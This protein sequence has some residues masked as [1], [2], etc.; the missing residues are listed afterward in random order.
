MIQKTAKKTRFVDNGDGT[1]TD[2]DNNVMWV[3]NDTWLE[4]GRQVTWHESQD[5]ARKMNEK[6][7]AG[8]GNWRIPT[9]SE[10]R[11][12]FDAEASN[13]DVEG[14]EIH[15]SPVFSPKCG[16]S[17]WTSETRGAKA[18]MGYDLRSDY[19][20][21]LAKENDGFPSAV[22]LVRQLQ[23]AATLKDGEPRFINNG[24]GTVTDSETGLMWKS[25]DSY[26]ELDKW[27]TW[28]EAKTYVQVLNRQYFATY[29]DWKMPTRKEVQT[30]FD[31][32]NPLQ[33][34][35]AIRFCWPRSFRPVRGN[36]AGR[37]PCIKPTSNSPF[38]FSFTT[39]ITNGIE[40]G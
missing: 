12:L 35:T 11:M 19:E 24:D 25:D 22:R 37:K 10:A 3:K 20:F 26:L 8:Y 30:I 13:A 7:F 2:V 27:V 16:F 31:P 1:V 28:N 4:L 21:W 18:A 39:V 40:W 17:T 38:V 32:A 36:P 6:K 14:G 34:N 9:G 33:I 5:Y 23:D 29:T 15:L